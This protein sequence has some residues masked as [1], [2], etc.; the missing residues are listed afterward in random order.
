MKL[1]LLFSFIMLVASNTTFDD[2]WASFKRE[3]TKVY[4]GPSEEAE[5]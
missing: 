1:I 3:H 5:R 4:K 2:D